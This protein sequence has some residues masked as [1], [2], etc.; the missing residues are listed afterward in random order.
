MLTQEKCC[1]PATSLVLN[2]K[3]RSGA[4]RLEPLELGR[5]RA[6]EALHVDVSIDTRAVTP[7]TSGGP[8][9]V[10]LEPFGTQFENISNT[11]SCKSSNEPGRTPLSS[12]KLV[13]DVPVEI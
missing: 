12:T 9:P 13:P 6:R 2:G 4:S 11:Y 1:F 7:V 8:A 10:P 5:L 3:I